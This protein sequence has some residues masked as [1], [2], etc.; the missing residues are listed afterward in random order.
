MKCELLITL[1]LFPMCT[2]F[3]IVVYIARVL[4]ITIS[5]RCIY[6][7]CVDVVR[8]VILHAWID[9]LKP[10]YPTDDCSTNGYLL[11]QLQAI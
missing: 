9:Y 7:L 1:Y 3:E 4:H 5:Y 11:F 10:L 8:E 6:V 2:L